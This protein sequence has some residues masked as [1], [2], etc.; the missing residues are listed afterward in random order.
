MHGLFD[1]RPDDFFGVGVFDNELSKTVF[2]DKVDDPWGAEVFCK[3]EITPAILFS[4][5]LQ[6]LSASNK[7]VYG[8]TLLPEKLQVE[9]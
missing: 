6:Y 7:R 8:A 1:S 9:F 3:F 2:Q 4:S 5:N